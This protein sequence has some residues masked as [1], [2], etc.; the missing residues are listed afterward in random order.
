MTKD[1]NM[2]YE[3]DKDLDKELK[4]LK[5]IDHILDASSGKAEKF[6]RESLLKQEAIK[7]VK[8]ICSGW[9]FEQI[10][11]TYWDWIKFFNITEEDLKE[12]KR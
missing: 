9:D 1:Y 2:Q 12:K 4:T 6:Y 7:W 8:H 10:N 11:N 3:I 5:D